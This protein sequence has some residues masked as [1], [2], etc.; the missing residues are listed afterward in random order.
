MPSAW[1][2]LLAVAIAAIAQSQETE[3]LLPLEN[4][5]PLGL[6]NALV[7]DPTSD[8]ASPAVL[9]GLREQ[10][11]SSLLR[12][13]PNDNA[14]GYLVETSP[15]PLDRMN[16]L[17]CQPGLG[18]YAI[19]VS[20]LSV[21]RNQTASVWTVLRSA[22]AGDS[23]TVEDRFF[24]GKDP[25]TSLAT[26]L[27]TDWQGNVLVAGVA[28]SGREQRWVIRRKPL[29]GSWEEVSN[30]KARS[31]NVLPAI[32]AFPGNPLDPTPA[33]IAVSE[34]NSKWT[35]LR[36]QQQGAKGTWQVMDSWPGDTASESMAVDAIYDSASGR[37]Y[38]CG[39]RGINGLNPS[40]WRVRMSP[41]GGTT[42]QTVLDQ[43]V[44]ASWAYRMAA[45]GTGGILVSGVVNPSGTTPL[46]TLVRNDPGQLWQDDPAGEDSWSLRAVLTDR[47]SRA[48]DVLVDLQ[49]NVFLTGGIAGWS[50]PADTAF[51]VYLL[52][53][54]AASDAP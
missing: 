46:W 42:W 52:R 34:I 29:G 19:G 2:L 22:D 12:L 32:A 48:G 41:D 13:T 40:G 30:L 53:L 26:G 21:R 9:V 24:L 50:D 8:P 37:L 17:T 38:V 35:V 54:A 44:G 47:Y 3:V 51:R 36:S 20:P 1:F 5:T 45:D 15:N 7:L 27:T 43:S 49:G 14:T 18:V 11:G 28:T 4:G 25:T 39:C 33:V 23:W 31:I 16:R 6:G 10:Q